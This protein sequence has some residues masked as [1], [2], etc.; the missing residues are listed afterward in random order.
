LLTIGRPPVRRPSTG[1][2]LDDRRF[3]TRTLGRFI[4]AIIVLRTGVQLASE[5]YASQTAQRDVMTASKDLGEA[6]FAFFEAAK[7]ESERSLRE[8]D[9]PPRRR[10]LRLPGRR[11]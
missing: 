10:R 8:L 5:R 1:A 11:S 3:V 6:P 4:G 9:D 7:T 2:L